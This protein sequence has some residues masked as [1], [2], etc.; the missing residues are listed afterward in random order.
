MDTTDL[1]LCLVR[2]AGI[3]KLPLEIEEKV[4]QEDIF[5][6]KEL[7]LLIHVL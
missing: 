1:Q 3:P 5:E 4:D 6:P 7:V 2:V